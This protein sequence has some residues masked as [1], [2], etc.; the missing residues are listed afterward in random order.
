MKIDEKGRLFGKINIIDL[1]VV[2][3]LIAVLCFAGYKFIGD[4]GTQS[5][6]IVMK[7]MTEEVS[8]FVLDKINIG[9]V[10][11]DDLNNVPL[12]KVTNIEKGPS[13][14]WAA[15]TDGE[16]VASDR[17]G[18]SSAIIT[19]ELEGKMYEHGALVQNSKYGVGHSATFRFGIGKIWARVYDIEELKE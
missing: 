13:I 8:D 4:K 15:N 2:I 1:L 19:T 9:D 10:V 17:E 18:W 11:S 12:G 7:I 5:Q 6:K 14:S 3:V 16:Y